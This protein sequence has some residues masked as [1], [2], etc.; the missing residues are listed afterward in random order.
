VPE[1]S[2]AIR[3]P[4]AEVTN[5]SQELLPG[6]PTPGELRLGGQ[7]PRHLLGDDALDLP[8]TSGMPTRTSAVIT[9]FRAVPRGRSAGPAGDLAGHADDRGPAGAPSGPQRSSRST[10]RSPLRKVRAMLGSRSAST[11]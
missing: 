5:S 4:S 3:V 10:T 11:P 8:P 7:Q 2:K 9:S 6:E 1:I